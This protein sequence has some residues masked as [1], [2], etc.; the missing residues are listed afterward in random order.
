MGTEFSNIE[1]VFCYD[2]NG[3]MIRLNDISS[4][5]ISRSS[6]GLSA[7]DGKGNMLLNAPN[8]DG[9][10]ITFTCECKNFD[11]LLEQ[12]ITQTASTEEKEDRYFSERKVRFREKIDF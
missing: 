8:R 12:A 2:E 9:Y 11:I 4:P 6:Y 3:N 7:Y 10:S 1:K 5:E